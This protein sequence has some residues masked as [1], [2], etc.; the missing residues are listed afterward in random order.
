MT[1]TQLKSIGEARLKMRRLWVQC[2]A[3]DGVDPGE[4]FV[5]FSPGNLYVEAHNTATVAYQRALA[6]AAGLL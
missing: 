2:C 6:Q 1:A 4:T 5:V 3:F